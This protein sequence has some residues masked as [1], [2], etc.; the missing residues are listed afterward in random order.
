MRAHAS[1]PNRNCREDIFATLYFNSALKTSRGSAICADFNSLPRKAVTSVL[2]E[3]RMNAT[4]NVSA[5]FNNDQADFIRANSTI[6][7]YDISEKQIVQFCNQFDPGVSAAYDN[8]CEKF[9]A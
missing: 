7:L 6:A 4:E 5:G 3:L 8:E 2:R 9:A 1:R